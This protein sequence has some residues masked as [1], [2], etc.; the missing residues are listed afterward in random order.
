MGKL[1]I[2][3]TKIPSD[4]VEELKLKTGK[5]TIKEALSEAVYHYLYCP[6]ANKIDESIERCKRGRKPLYLKEI[7]E[8]H[9]S[10]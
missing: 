7:S 3:Q 10:E 6:L 9:G 2:V 1:L 5:S 8:T 4:K